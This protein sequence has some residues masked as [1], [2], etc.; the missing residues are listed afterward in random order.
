MILLIGGLVVMGIMAV[1]VLKV[2]Q[3][4]DDQTASTLKD[5]NA[6]TG[7][8]TTAAPGAATSLPGIEG[9]AQQQACTLEKQTVSQ[10]EEIGSTLETRPLT[11]EELVALKYLKELPAHYVVVVNPDGTTTVRSKVPAVCP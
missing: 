1:I 2:M 5:L 10:A 6:V 4:Q 8:S 9:A 7:S 3:S 11:T